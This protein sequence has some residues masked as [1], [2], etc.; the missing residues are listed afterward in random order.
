M[1]N[2]G[3][4]YAYRAARRDG[5]LEIGVLDADSRAEASAALAERGL[6]PLEISVARE[7]ASERPSMPA[8][9]LAVGLRVLSTLLESGLPMTKALAAMSELV[10]ESWEPVIA[11]LTTSVRAGRSLGASLAAAPI[12]IPAVVVGIVQAGEGGSGIAL[13]VRRAAELTEGTAARRAAVRAALAYPI[14]LAAAGSASVALLVGVVLPRFSAILADLGQ[15]LPPAT[16][17]VLTLAAVVRAGALPAALAGVA[18]AIGWRA[19]VRTD[20]GARRWHEL[21]LGIPLVGE[22]RR[23][24]ASSRVCAALASLLESGVP[25]SPALAHASRAAGDAEI[26]ARVRTARE[27][28]VAG[29]GMARSLGAVGAVTPTA[30]RLARAGEE[31]GQMATMLWHASRLDGEQAERMLKSAVRLLEPSMIIVFGGMVALVAAAL[32][33]AIYSVRAT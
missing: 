32:L 13:A 8:G 28:V 4:A 11:S 2:T 30:V 29:Q 27:S 1:S 5:G 10:P 22:I 21:L 6:F 20:D 12:E 7:E 33:Q 31:S 24:A 18:I 25:A 14:I 16:R 9:D 23:A 19:W 3:A 17:L 15:A 26:A